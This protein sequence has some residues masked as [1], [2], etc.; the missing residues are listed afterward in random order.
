MPA[1][2][3]KGV[4][5]EED[6]WNLQNPLSH[7]EMSPFPSFCVLS[8]HQHSNTPGT[9]ARMSSKGMEEAIFIYSSNLR[10]LILCSLGKM[11]VKCPKTK[12]SV[13]RGLLMCEEVLPCLPLEEGGKATQSRLGYKVSHI[14]VAQKSSPKPTQSTASRWCF[15]GHVTW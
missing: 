11:K 13:D 10:N 3:L 9:E 5:S 15:V 12:E 6:S 4:Y 14:C 8:S 1:N 2:L 7:C